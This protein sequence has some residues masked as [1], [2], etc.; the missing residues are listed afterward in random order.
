MRDGECVE[1]IAVAAEVSAAALAGGGKLLVFGN[2]G[3]AADALHIA[4][5]FVGRY[6]IERAP[7]PA[8]ALVANP[9]AVTAIGNDYGFENVFARQVRALGKAGD[10]ALGL[11]TSGRSPNVARGLEAAGQLDMATIAMTGADPGPVGDRGRAADR[12]TELRDAADPG[13]PHARRPHRLRVGRGEAGGGGRPGLSGPRLLPGRTAF[14]DRD[15]TINE[16]AAEG[17]YITAPDQVRLLPGAAEAIR[18]LNELPA[19]VVVVTNQR[20][21]RWG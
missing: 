5:E 13:G 21:S 4:A 8:I 2:G 1:Q 16:S 14:L 17:D 12:D 10:V 7:L 3:S 20:G 6:L 9:S 18:L 15:G 19:R 11:T